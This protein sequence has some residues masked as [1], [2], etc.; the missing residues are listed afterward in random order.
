[1][2][3]GMMQRGLTEEQQAELKE[4]FD[5]FDADKSGQIDFKELKAAFKA[6]GFQVP[7]EELKKM[8]NDVDTDGSG[9]IEFPEFLQMMTAR[10]KKETREEID[11]VHKLFAPE[12]GAITHANL[13]RVAK[14]LGEAMTE[15]ELKEMIEHADKSQS[16]S[17]S[18]DDFYRLMMK[19]G[20]G[21]KLD[22]L[23]GDEED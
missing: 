14:E 18:T 16:G 4:A 9:E 6:L 8:F 21:N 17:V 7:K 3:K 1:M 12:G 22:D 15:E 19:G 5:L 13:V 11:K 10:T 23:L 2:P 20:S